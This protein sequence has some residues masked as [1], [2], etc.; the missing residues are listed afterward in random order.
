MIV[1]HWKVE[2]LIQQLKH[3]KHPMQD[4]NTKHPML[5]LRNIFQISFATIIFSLNNLGL[6]RAQKSFKIQTFGVNSKFWKIFF[7][8]QKTHSMDLEDSVQLQNLDD[9]L[10]DINDLN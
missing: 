6:S 10:D 8:M 5:M 7:K 4:I 1:Q 2:I 3:Q 9:L